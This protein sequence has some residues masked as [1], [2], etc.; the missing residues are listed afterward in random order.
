[1]SILVGNNKAGFSPTMLSSRHTYLK[2]SH[3]SALCDAKQATLLPH[4]KQARNF[5]TGSEEPPTV[6]TGF[7]EI[8]RGDFPIVNPL[9]PTAND[10]HK[11]VR[12]LDIPSCTLFSEQRTLDTRHHRSSEAL[13]FWLGSTRQDPA[14]PYFLL[15]TPINN[16]RFFSVVRC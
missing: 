5:I 1:M 3:L 8:F 9:P 14:Q 4:K 11:L 13:A 15:G 10:D 16:V 7:I 2:A 6:C 12:C